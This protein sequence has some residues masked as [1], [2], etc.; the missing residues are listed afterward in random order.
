MRIAQISTVCAPVR[1]NARGSVESLVWLLT[2][3]LAR[4]GHEV[5]VFG[6]AGSEV[7]GE[8]VETL[9]G[10]YARDGAPF[11][12]QV[13]EWM[14]LC[15]AIQQ[16]GRFDVLHSHA[17]LWGIPLQRLSRV[18]MIHTMHVSP[19]ENDARLWSSEPAARVTALSHFQWSRFPQLHP[20]AVIYHGV[21]TSSFTFREKPDDYLCY[22]GRFIPGKGPLEAI[23]VAQEV[24]LPL[25]LAGPR[26]IYFRDRIEPLVDGEQI[27]YAGFVAGEERDRLLGGARALLYPV[28]APEPFGLVLAEAMMCGTPVVAMRR[29][30]APEIV[31]QGITGFCTDSSDELAGLVEQSKRLDRARVRRRAE[32]RFGAARMASE[33]LALYQRMTY[34]AVPA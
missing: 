5:T 27:R 30:A 10:S 29:G 14:N 1:R 28:Q 32:A 19:Y 11:D 18:P 21:D 8:L 23:R 20:S 26:N 2:R 17:Y 6:V 13:C 16:S 34:Q 9:P 33:Y 4:L 25:V 7:C 31:N 12:W 3:E 22:L 24:G 15:A